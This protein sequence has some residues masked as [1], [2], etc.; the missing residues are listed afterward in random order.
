MT[1]IRVCAN[2]IS[3]RRG[4][5]S[6][7]LYYLKWPPSALILS[8]TI[9]SRKPLQESFWNLAW[10]WEHLWEQN[11]SKRIFDIWHYFCDFAWSMVFLG[12]NGPKMRF[13]PLFSKTVPT[14]FLK[15]SH[16]QAPYQIS[17]HYIYKYMLS[18]CIWYFI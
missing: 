5:Y 18:F 10:S 2:R 8:V 6:V 13:L 1:K 9:V 4:P 14:I 11:V 3:P 12:Q 15:N 16:P 17:N 7:Y